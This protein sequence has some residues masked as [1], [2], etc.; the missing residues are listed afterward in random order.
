ME[1]VCD[2][3]TKPFINPDSCKAVLLML[4]QSNLR[5]NMNGEA[6]VQL[7]RATCSARILQGTIRMLKLTRMHTVDT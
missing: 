1:G 3:P 4:M 7:R 6:E 5:C 2:A